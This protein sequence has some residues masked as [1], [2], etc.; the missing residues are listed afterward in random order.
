VAAVLLRC[1]LLLGGEF[2]LVS[3]GDWDLEWVVG[4]RVGQPGARPLLAALFGDVPARS[5]LSRPLALAVPQPGP[6][7][8]T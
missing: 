1:H 4:A 8:S 3:D 5:P 7:R 6:S 2:L